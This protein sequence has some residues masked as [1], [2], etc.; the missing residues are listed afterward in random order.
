MGDSQLN[1]RKL[2][3]NGY[4][5]WSDAFNFIYYE[6]DEEFGAKQIISI[7]L[8]VL[9]VIGAVVGVFMYC[10][11]RKAGQHSFNQEQAMANVVVKSEKK[12]ADAPKSPKSKS[13][14][15]KNANAYRTAD[16]G[17]E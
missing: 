9:L 2:G 3:T 7:C 12:D 5:R 1:N 11:K 13:R 16:A 14:E 6:E 15:T 8:A 10:K 17:A 4:G